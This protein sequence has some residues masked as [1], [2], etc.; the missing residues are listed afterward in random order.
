MWVDQDVYLITLVLVPHGLMPFS[1][2]PFS[3]DLLWLLKGL[4]YFWDYFCVITIVTC[5]IFR[6][7]WVFE[8][9]EYADENAVFDCVAMSK[10]ACK[11]SDFLGQ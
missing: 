10:K 11:K 4:N 5:S 9:G 7:G 6:G 3:L 8:G 1:Q 2:N